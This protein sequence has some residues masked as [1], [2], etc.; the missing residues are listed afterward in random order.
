MQQPGHLAAVAQR[1]AHGA[2]RV[3][4]PGSA[5][6]GPDSQATQGPVVGA[7]GLPPG[8]GRALA[9]LGGSEALFLSVGRNYPL[10][11]REQAVRLQGALGEANWSAAARQSHSLR[12]VA[13]T[14]GAEALAAYLLALEARL[15]ADPASLQ[16]AGECAQ[17]GAE[18]EHSI[19]E[20]AQACAVLEAR[21]AILAS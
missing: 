2:G 15:R 6:A 19:G 1:P 4:R 13:G 20:L 12:G 21:R 3:H 7:P 9:R 16:V 11:A 14:V 5:V 10:E 8:A 18:V 17:V